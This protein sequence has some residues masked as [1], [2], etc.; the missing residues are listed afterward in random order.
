[1]HLLTQFG[2][3]GFEADT[4]IEIMNNMINNMATLTKSA[5]I[6]FMIFTPLIKYFSFNDLNIDSFIVVMI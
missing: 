3:F 1:M 6:F 4:D 2:S 5:E